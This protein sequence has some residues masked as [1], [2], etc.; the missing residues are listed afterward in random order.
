MG[1]PGRGE[2]TVAPRNLQS[3]E[4]STRCKLNV[5]SFTYQPLLFLFSFFFFKYR[6]TI[7]NIVQA[8]EGE[9]KFRN[10]IY[11]RNHRYFILRIKK[12]FC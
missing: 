2:G 12:S 11:V 5:R 8:R 10:S 6:S 4:S 1:R 7:F 3:F 9:S